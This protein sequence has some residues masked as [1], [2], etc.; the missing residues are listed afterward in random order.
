[1]VC[2][3]IRNVSK[4]SVQGVSTTVGWGQGR[5]LKFFVWLWQITKFNCS[6]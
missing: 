3:E 4:I 2:V 6:C 1:M 5:P